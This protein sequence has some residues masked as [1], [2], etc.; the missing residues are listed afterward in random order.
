MQATA[1]GIPQ[2]SEP[3]PQSRGIGLVQFGVFQLIL[4]FPVH[5]PSAAGSTRA[6]QCLGGLTRHSNSSD[7]HLK[8][9]QL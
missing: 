8:V 6:E 3:R 5:Y 7:N 4:K 1:L 9:E 2:R